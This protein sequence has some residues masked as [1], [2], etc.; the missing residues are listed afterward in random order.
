MWILLFLLFIQANSNPRQAS[1]TPTQAP[2][3]IVQV[4]DPNWQPLPSAKV[5]VKQIHGDAQS[6]SNPA[7]TDKDGYANFTAPGDADYAI[8]A[9]LYG[10]KRA[11]VSPVH[12][13]K[14]SGSSSTAYVQIKMR[15]SGPGI[16]V[17]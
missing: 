17:Y 7:E 2:S 8:E 9:D 10:F 4:V 16:I 11:S 5:T 15:L 13:F 3:L 12:L 14:S 1:P 6:K